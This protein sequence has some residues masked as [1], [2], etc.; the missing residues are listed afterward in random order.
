[1]KGW[2]KAGWRC[3]A[4]R[5]CANGVLT[6]SCKG[7]PK[8]QF[9]VLCLLTPPPNYYHHHR[10]WLAFCPSVGRLLLLASFCC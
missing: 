6:A 10:C 2:Q 1:M 9:V 3:P 8:L 7:P 4:L 5:A